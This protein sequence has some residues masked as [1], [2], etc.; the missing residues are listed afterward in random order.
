MFIGHFA[1]GFA[2]KAVAPKAN[3]GTAFAAAQWL[4]LVWP[5]LVL[6]GIEHVSIVPGATAFSPFDFSYYPY[7]HSLLAACLWGLLFGGVYYALRRDARTATWLGLLVV[8]HWVL[9]WI[10]HRPDMPL[11]PGMGPR[12]GLGLWYSVPATLA[13]ELC[14]FAV[15]IAVYTWVTRA[16]NA[17]GR[18]ALVALIV[19]FLAMYFGSRIGLPPSAAAMAGGGLVIIALF[20]AWGWWVDR[21]RVAR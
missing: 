7:S 5:P 17:L 12:V 20:C 13:V 8:S 6:L 10:S 21:Q 4:D 15:G 3:L 11:I 16:Q 19:A 1:L 14:L 18:W 9:D 2:S